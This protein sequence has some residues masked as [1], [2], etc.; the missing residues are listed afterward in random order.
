MSRRVTLCLAL[1]RTAAV[2]P[3]LDGQVEA[4]GIELIPAVASPGDLF[5]RQLHRREF[6]ASEFSLSS[7]MVLAGRGDTTWTAIP[8]FPSRGF[9]HTQILVRRGA[10][11]GTPADLRGRRVGVPEY[12]QT[13]AL[14]TRGVL[15]HEFGVRPGDMEWVMGRAPARSHALATGFR[16]P[17]GVRLGY[18]PEGE[19]LGSLVASGRLDALIAYRTRRSGLGLGQEP[20][21]SEHDDAAGIAGTEVADLGAG[22]TLTRLF[23]EPVAEGIRYYRATGIFPVAHT[24]VVRAALAE[25]HPWLPGSL[26]E[27][28]RRARE[29]AFR[30]LC[31]QLEPYAAVGAV[32]PDEIGRAQRAAPF[33][34]TGNEATLRAAARYAREQ[35]LTPGPVRPD[36]LF[37]AGAGA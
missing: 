22:G 2:A 17:A 25:R 5:W 16:P 15:Q 20:A 29:L 8:V 32:D 24:V 35:G 30:R 11:I 21:A 27:A 23:A 19:S 14:W 13:A 37:F 26:Y 9:F 7:L 31:V 10:G 12:Q 4:E 33:G 28:F 1:S 18:V 3:L 6:D 36:E 34:I